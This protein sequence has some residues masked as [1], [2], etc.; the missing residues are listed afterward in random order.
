MN[1][2][3]SRIQSLMAI[4]GMWIIHQLLAV[5]LK[6]LIANHPS[7]TTCGFSVAEV[8]IIT[9]SSLGFVLLMSLLLLLNWN[10]SIRFAY[11]TIVT[12]SVMFALAIVWLWQISHFLITIKAMI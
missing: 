8:Q 10:Q 9:S 5:V 1:D 11:L 7:K 6:S 3:F 4:A 12:E 2:Q